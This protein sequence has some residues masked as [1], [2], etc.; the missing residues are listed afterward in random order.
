MSERL[1]LNP[2]SNPADAEALLKQL[3]AKARLGPSS[4]GLG[5]DLRSVRPCLHALFESAYEL[6][7]SRV[8]GCYTNS[9]PLEDGWEIQP[10]VCQPSLPGI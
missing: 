6:P 2:P 1:L 9:H 8:P 7:L 10:Q 5:A 3:Y 4:D